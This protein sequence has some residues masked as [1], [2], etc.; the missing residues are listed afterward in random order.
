MLLTEKGHFLG[1]ERFPTDNFPRRDSPRAHQSRMPQIFGSGFFF[2]RKKSADVLR[3]FDLGQGAL[4]ETRL[5]HPDRK[6]RVPGEYFYLSQGNIKDAFLLERSPM[7]KQ[8][9]SKQL[10]KIP[11]NPTNDQLYFAEAAL[12][13]PDIWWDRKIGT[14]FF[15][16]D[17]LAEALKRA[18]VAADWQLLRCP[19]VT[20]NDA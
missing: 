17:R 6:T 9:P 8:Y 15:I 12:N 18:R 5:W 14:Y 19:I 11:P 10:W 2:V 16:S 7:A 3:Q 1:R 20:G 4:Y 13:G